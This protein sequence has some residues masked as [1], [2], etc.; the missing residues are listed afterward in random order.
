MRFS[1]VR[2]SRL[3]VLFGGLAMCVGAARASFVTGGAG[4][5][6]PYNASGASATI[7][8]AVFNRT[9][10]TAGD[11][12]GTGTTNF[13]SFFA[14][15]VGSGA[16]DTTAQF[17]YLYETVAIGPGSSSGVDV[18]TVAAKPGLV[19]SYGD[20]TGAEFSTQVLGT[21][22]GYANPSNASTDGTPAILGGQTGLDAPFV[23]L[24]STSLQAQFFTELASGQAST[25]WGYT[26]NSPMS[27]GS[28]A[29]LSGSASGANGL[30]PTAA[31]PEPSSFAMITVCALLAGLRR[32]KP[33]RSS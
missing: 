17:L 26:S 6:Q 23:F 31:T 9:G 3:F 13:N 30:V 16:F 27:F 1:F 19:T 32:L 11:T 12:F 22:A 14:T 18:N 7:D 28:T 15:G 8:F 10:G 33:S 29:I 25:L 20:F 24:G 5:T 2:K 4:N 21:P